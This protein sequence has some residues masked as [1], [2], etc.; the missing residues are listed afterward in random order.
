MASNGEIIATG[1]S[2]ESKAAC[3][4]GIASIQ[5]NAP[6]AEIVDETVK[7]EAVKETVEKKPV[8]KKTKEPVE[9]SAKE[10]A[11]KKPR[12]KKAVTEE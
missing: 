9:D 7:K 6:V 3:L 12:R 8:R 5:K 2:Y 1:E 4:K 11:E 10:T